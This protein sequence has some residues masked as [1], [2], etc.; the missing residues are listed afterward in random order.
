MVGP[1]PPPSAGLKFVDG[2]VTGFQYNAHLDVNSVQLKKEGAGILN[3]EFKPHTAGAVLSVT[4]KGNLVKI[5]YSTQ[6]NDEAIVY[7]L[8]TIKDISSGNEIDVDRLPPPPRIPPGKPAQTFN[9]INPRVITDSYG[10]V[11][12]LQA[13]GKL[14]HFRPEQVEDIQSL[15]KN[16]H[17]FTLLAV[18]RGEQG[19]I[20]INHDEVFLVISI[21]IDNKTFTIR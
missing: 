11:D 10:G 12:A 20:N 2:A 13:P 3:F 4:K 21:T 7:H 15:I 19:F 14:F 1:P 17:N 6:P 5:G 9:I 18:A 16:G 8:H